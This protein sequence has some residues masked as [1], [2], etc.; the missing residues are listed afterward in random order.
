MPLG[1]QADGLRARG[2]S[3]TKSATLASK[4]GREMDKK[5]DSHS[6]WVQASSGKALCG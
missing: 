6:E 1:P 5:L 2:G 3:T 4:V